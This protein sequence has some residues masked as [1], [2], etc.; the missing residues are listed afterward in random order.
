VVIVNRKLA[1]HYW[2]GQEAVGKRLHLGPLEAQ[3]PWL[4]IVGEV[5]ARAGPNPD[6][7]IRRW[8]RTAPC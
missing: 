5:A 3:T 4:T 7:K 8:R 2:P 1:E 6:R